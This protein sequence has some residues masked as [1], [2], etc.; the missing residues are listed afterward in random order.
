MHN[1]A[2][3]DHAYDDR[4]HCKSSEIAEGTGCVHADYLRV[5]KNSWCD[6][7]VAGDQNQVLVWREQQF[8]TPTIVDAD[9]GAS[10]KLES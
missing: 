8:F 5:G 3:Y 9:G 4:F 7:E 6:Y 1:D 2:Y 10:F